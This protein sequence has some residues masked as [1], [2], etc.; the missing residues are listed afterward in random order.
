MRFPRI[1]ASFFWF[2]TDYRSGAKGVADP[3]DYNRFD[4][5]DGPLIY[6]PGDND[7]AD[8]DRVLADGNDTRKKPGE[9]QRIFF[10]DMMN[11]G[12]APTIPK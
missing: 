2:F 5:F 3:K 10:A 6:T 1:G 4:S 7:W 12:S 8:C 11:M 9:I